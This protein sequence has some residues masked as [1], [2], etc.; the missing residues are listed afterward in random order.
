M[1]KKLISSNFISFILGN[2]F[3]F[4][5]MFKKKTVVFLF[6][7]TTFK[8]SQFHQEYN[9]NISPDLFSEQIQI[10]KKNF[11]VITP[12]TLLKGNYKTPA[13]LITFDDGSKGNFEYA[14]PILEKL[15]CPSLMFLN[16]API[17]GDIFWSGL[18]TYLC[19]NH[20]SFKRNYINSKKNLKK[21]YFLNIHPKEIDEFLINNNK[22]EIYKNAR[23]YYGEFINEDDLLIMSN[24]KYL[25]IG[26]HLY[27]HYNCTYCTSNEIKENFNKNQIQLD[28]YTNSTKLFSYPFGQ[29]NTCYNHTT[30]EIIYS[31]GAEA[32]FAAHPDNFKHKEKLYYRF[33]ITDK[34]KSENFIRM[35]LIL[36]KTINYFSN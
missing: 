5:S 3:L 35:M 29:E 16:M 23:K 15:K 2:K 36:R 20:N 28:K 19:N 27:Q 11:N 14:Y 34:Y 22:E 6:H 10:I 25:E 26:N 1:I 7:E 9:L 8:P 30:N 12:K 24:S 4:N 17:K 13:A 32:I 31:L 21:P 33:A 18:I